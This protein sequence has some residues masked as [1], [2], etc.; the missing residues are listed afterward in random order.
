MHGRDTFL[1]IR[2]HLALAASVAISVSPN[3]AG[4]FAAA[5]DDGALGWLRWTRDP[6]AESCLGAVEFASRVEAQLGEPPAAAARRSRRRI[7]VRLARR[8]D[9]PV[10]WSADLT[11]L[12]A[13]D[14]VAGTRRIDRGDDSC[15]PLGEAL[16]LIAALILSEGAE[17]GA[18]RPPVVAPVSPPTKPAP[19]AAPPP[20]NLPAPPAPPPPP[21]EPPAATPPAPSSA[22]AALSGPAPALPPPGAAPPPLPLESPAPVPPPV[23]RAPP[24]VV[25]SRPAPPPPKS[26]SSSASAWGASLAAGPVAGVGLLPNLAWAGEAR[27]A[28]VPPA[29]P[30]L[31][32][33]ATVWRS[34]SA[35]ALD[36]ASGARLGLWTVG[37][38]LSPL[39][40]VGKSRAFGAWVG[41]EVGR[42]QAAGFGFDTPFDKE[43]WV[44]DLSVGGRL[45]QQI[46]GR[47]FVEIDVR[48]VAP[49]L[50]NR[51]TFVDASGASG[52]L[53]RM[54]PV[55]P[56]GG[57]EIGYAL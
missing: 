54:W 37:L 48:A 50:R 39:A 34:E 25:R 16:V 3:A 5:D 20:R 1:G 29:W 40:R 55:A 15:A 33:S 10:R 26:S 36:G 27:F 18:G 35:V 46:G 2:R 45:R 22:P 57:L 31:L 8:A 13:D 41:A 4:A 12:A 28:L 11:L 56:V 21:P 24:P 44:V 6:G 14:I 51:I 38:A 49:L 19:P 17:T 30:P 47:F 52:E 32:V 23:Q 9:A 43:S 53:F 42:L 7:S